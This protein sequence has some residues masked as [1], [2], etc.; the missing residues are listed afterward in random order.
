MRDDITD[1]PGFLAGS[2]EDPVA[3]TGCSVVLCPAEGAVAG[4]DQRG[5]AGGTR[6]TDPLGV[7]HIVEKVHGVLLTGG[8][9][10]GLD[11]AGGVVRYLE[12]RGIGFATRG[13]CVPI[14]PAAVLYDLG[15]GRSDLRPDADM[16]ERACS[17][18]E[19]GAALRLG[20]AGA[21]CGATIGKILGPARA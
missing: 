10:F 2:A 19:T 16:A 9:A 6:E 15:I 14:V 13:G 18:A 5:G 17:E 3:L 12:R 4:F 8:S 1:V 11:A 20:N 7:A 21:G